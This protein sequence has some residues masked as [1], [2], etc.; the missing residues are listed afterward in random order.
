MVTYIHKTVGGGRGT[1]GDWV[2]MFGNFVTIDICLS[3]SLAS[4]VLN[5]QLAH[6]SVKQG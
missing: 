2:E 4:E 6:Y 5:H 1:A 3:T